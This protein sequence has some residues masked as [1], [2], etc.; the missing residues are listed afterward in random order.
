MLTWALCTHTLLVAQS[1][2]VLGDRQA[3]MSRVEVTAVQRQCD[4][5]AMEKGVFPLSHV[6]STL[7]TQI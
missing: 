6:T 3:A 2:T 4:C 5:C 7:L 1:Y